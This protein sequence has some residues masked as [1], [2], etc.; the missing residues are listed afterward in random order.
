MSCIYEN[1]NKNNLVKRPKI[2]VV[3]DDMI[4]NITGNKKINPVVTE[5]FIRW[6]KLNISFAI[7]IQLYFEVPRC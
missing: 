1:I 2:L 5:A 7:V 3:F 4:T 6:R